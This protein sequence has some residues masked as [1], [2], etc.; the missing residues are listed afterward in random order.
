MTSIS[1]FVD[2]P[3]VGAEVYTL[4]AGTTM[5]VTGEGSGS[6]LA[7]QDLTCTVDA[8]AQSCNAAGSV[9]LGAGQLFDVKVVFGNGSAPSPHDAIVAVICE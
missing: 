1:V 6:D 3:A 9:S 4:R 7:D 5:V 2:S 8:D